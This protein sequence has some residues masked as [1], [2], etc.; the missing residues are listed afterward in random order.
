MNRWDW[1]LPAT[2]AMLDESRYKPLD[3]PSENIAERLVMLGHLT[4]NSRIWSTRLDAY[5]TAYTNHIRSSANVADVAHWWC[6]LMGRMVGT[7]LGA[8]SLL[9]E[10]NLLVRPTSL[11]ETAVPDE[12][13]LMHFRT[14]ALDLVD[15]TR[16]W[17]RDRRGIKD[18]LAQQEAEVANEEVV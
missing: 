1:P 3:E 13:V 11:P 10:K 7:P 18:F 16:I 4:F 2:D 15:R 6:T 5:W 9:H 12:D 8:T 17:V 14:Y